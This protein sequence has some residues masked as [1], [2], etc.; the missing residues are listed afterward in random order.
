MISIQNIGENAFLEQKNNVVK[1]LKPIHRVQVM[2]KHDNVN[3]KVVDAAKLENVEGL[4]GRFLAPGAY[5]VQKSDD[6]D[7]NKGFLLRAFY[8]ITVVSF[9]EKKEMTFSTVF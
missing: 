5:Q 9:T 3:F 7:D 4:I 2:E 8:S 6:G 1:I